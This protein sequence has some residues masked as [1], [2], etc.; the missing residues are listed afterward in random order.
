MEKRVIDY[1]LMTAVLL[2]LGIGV[3]IVYSSSAILSLEKFN[4]SYHYLKKEVLFA[5]LGLGLMV[6]FM[7]IGWFIHVDEDYHNEKKKIEFLDSI[8]REEFYSRMFG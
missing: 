6:V 7:S 1:Y 4:D 2:L 5:V 8:G 3:L